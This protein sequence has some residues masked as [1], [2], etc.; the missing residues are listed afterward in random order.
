MSEFDTED[1]QVEDLKKWWKENGKAVIVGAV[2][3]FSAIFGGRMYMGHLEEQ[4]IK[5]SIEYERMSMALQQQQAEEVFSRG[6]LIVTTYPDTAYAAL[7]S[8]AMARLYV[9]KGALA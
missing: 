2:L 6:D 8:L 4:R 7:A 3:G 1:Q 5:A 9:D